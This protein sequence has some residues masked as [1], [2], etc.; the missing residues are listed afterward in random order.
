MLKLV[1]FVGYIFFG[2]FFFIVVFF[3]CVYKIENRC[4]LYYVC[5]LMKK[6]IKKLVIVVELY[7]GFCF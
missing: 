2:F 6:V 5:G 4:K 3:I 1:V 7:C